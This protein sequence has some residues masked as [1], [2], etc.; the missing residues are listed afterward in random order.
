MPITGRVADILNE[1]ELVINRGSEAGVKEGTRFKITEPERTV[2]D[3]DTGE[4]LGN[5]SREKI[6]V[7]VVE[8][9]PKYSIGMTYQTFVIN[10]G[11]QLPSLGFGPPRQEV[12][13]VRTLRV[14]STGYPKPLDEASSFVDIG[15]TAVEVEETP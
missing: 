6:R 8:L 11:G 12:T 10:V 9:H 14:D 4:P 1:R 3:P 2:T 5:F 13:R 7:K 15:D